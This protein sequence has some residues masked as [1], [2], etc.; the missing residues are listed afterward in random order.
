MC[1]KE[2]AKV[3]FKHFTMEELNK[4]TQDQ[5]RGYVLAELVYG[6]GSALTKGMQSTPIPETAEAQMK[7]IALMKKAYVQSE[8]LLNNAM[9]EDTEAFEKMLQCAVGAPKALNYE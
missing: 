8:A 3:R 1:Q 2:V 5:Q 6:L 4:M 9:I 7:L